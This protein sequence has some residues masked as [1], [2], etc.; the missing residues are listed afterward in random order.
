MKQM[1]FAANRNCR[2]RELTSHIPEQEGAKFSCR[3]IVKVCFQRLLR[4]KKLGKE[5]LLFFLIVHFQT[6]SQ[7]SSVNPNKTLYIHYTIM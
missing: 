5:V 2:C 4:T 7:K 3:Q 6:A 1:L